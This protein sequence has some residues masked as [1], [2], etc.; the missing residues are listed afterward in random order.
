MTYALPYSKRIS[1]ESL[2]KPRKLCYHGEAEPT[3]A[4]SRFARKGV[5]WWLWSPRGE[6]PGALF[7]RSI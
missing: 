1:T 2:D 3:K 7:L 5:R 6:S 4:R